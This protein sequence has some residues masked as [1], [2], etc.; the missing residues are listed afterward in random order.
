MKQYLTELRRPW[1]GYRWAGPIVEADNY[2][3]ARRIMRDTPYRIMGELIHSFRQHDGD[4]S[5]YIQAGRDVV[6]H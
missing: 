1:Q 2:G 4:I 3:E 6:V 5:R